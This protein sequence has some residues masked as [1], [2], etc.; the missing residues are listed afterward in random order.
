M[1]HISSKYVTRYCTLLWNWSGVSDQCPIRAA[2][3]TTWNCLQYFS[4][5][6]HVTS[7][8]LWGSNLF[9]HGSVSVH[10]AHTMVCKEPLHRTLTSTFNTSEMS[11]NTISTPDLPLT[12]PQQ[13]SCSWM[14]TNPPRVSLQNVS[15]YNSKLG[16]TWN[17]IFNQHIR[18]EDSVR[19]CF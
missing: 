2:P 5:T 13:R 3:K 14:I 18:M 7:L 19:S 8:E 10:K 4:V 1:Q 6:N 11:W 15:H 16:W 12:W 17:M 9:R